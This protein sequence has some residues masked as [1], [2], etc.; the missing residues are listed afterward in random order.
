MARKRKRAN[1]Q[2]AAS[3][4]SQ[5]LKRAKVSNG[6]DLVAALAQHP[7][8]RLYY[9]RVTTLRDY[10]LSG[11][12]KT[13]KGRRRKI[14]NAGNN[15]SAV[16][17][18]S[19]TDRGAENTS[20]NAYTLKVS[21]NNDKALASVLDSTLVCKHNV[22]ESRPNHARSKDFEVFS[23]HLNLTATSSVGQGRSPLSELVD[24]AVWLLFHRVYRSAHR[25]PHMLC[26]GYQRA[27]TPKHVNE[28]HCAAAGIPGIVSHYPNGNVNILKGAVW[29]D[30]FALLGKDGEDIMLDMIL[31]C[32]VFA[33]VPAGKC[34]YFQLSGIP[35]TDL[36]P[37]KTTSSGNT[38]SSTNLTKN[39]STKRA[40]ESGRSVL[41][42]P[43]TITLVHSR[44]LYARPALNAKGKVTFGLRHIHA[45]NRY[46]ESTNLHQSIHLMTYIFPRQF[47]LHNVFTS[48]VDSR[49]TV[50]PFKDYTLRD[51]E[52]A[53]KQRRDGRRA[54]SKRDF[55][56]RIP[57]RLRGAPLALVQKL[58]QRHSRC[59]YRELLEHHC[60]KFANS[61][62]LQSKAQTVRN[63]RSSRRSRHGRSSAQ[64]DVT[65]TFLAA[66]EM[67]AFAG[68]ATSSIVHPDSLPSIDEGPNN[69]LIDLATSQAQV[70][71]FCQS[72]LSKLLPDGFWGEGEAKQ[73]HKSIVMGSV[74][75]FI[76]TRRFES[77]SL[78]AVSQGFKVCIM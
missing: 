14:A 24:F 72:T 69:S 22:P 28:D 3:I 34:N 15:A 8:L 60:P 41:N 12:P 51:Q 53:Q 19:S 78:H 63:S 56:Q 37:L 48:K 64:H 68:L 30:V 77:L 62:A 11:L 16:E 2:I 43:A 75:R 10:L 45:L 71:A 76:K 31:E 39:P 4:Q 47:G 6:N 66:T 50:Q 52:I 13:S 5:P 35:L 58:Q 59:S 55:E 18:P 44:M 61:S 65:D 23:Q 7:S 73:Q 70:S 9:P 1:N 49:E 74:S 21:A 33:S 57:K 67:P 20:K 40:A 46:P 36:Q 42:S 38:S 27:T 29:A 54:F 25:P 32:S 17:D 26:H